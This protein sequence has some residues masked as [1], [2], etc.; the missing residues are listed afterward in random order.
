MEFTIFAIIILI[1]IFV[2]QILS[3]NWHRFCKCN[4]ECRN[5]AC[6][7]AK[8]CEYNS[9]YHNNGQTKKYKFLSG[10]LI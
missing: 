5:I 4:K 2:A 7:R 1:Y 8:K 3:R 6:V 10:S 9:L